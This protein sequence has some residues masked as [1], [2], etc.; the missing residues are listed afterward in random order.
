MG[1]EKLQIADQPSATLTPS[2]LLANA[3]GGDREEEV[4]LVDAGGEAEGKRAAAAASRVS[5]RLASCAARNSAGG[6]GLNKEL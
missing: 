3:A 1:L 4:Q 5:Y 6:Q 2:T